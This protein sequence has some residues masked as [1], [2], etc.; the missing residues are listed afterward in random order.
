MAGPGGRAGPLGWARV[1][2]SQ[3]VLNILLI[4]SLNLLITPTNLLI[5]SI[6]F[7]WGYKLGDGLI[8]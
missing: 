4:T 8:I 6:N 2:V 3:F 7:N 1:L 5:T